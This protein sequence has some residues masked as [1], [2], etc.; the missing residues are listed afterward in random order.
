[1]AGAA[2]AVLVAVGIRVG[3]P[4]SWPVVRGDPAGAAA[5]MRRQCAVFRAGL[6]HVRSDVG[7]NRMRP[8]AEG[9]GE[10]RVGLCP[11]WRAAGAL[12]Q[13]V[14]VARVLRLQGWQ[15]A[16]RGRKAAVLVAPA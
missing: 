11:A 2:V 16:Y 12:A 13:E 14:S 7:G 6:Q 4:P 10:S 3:A 15:V 8:L 5:W 9:P 1:M